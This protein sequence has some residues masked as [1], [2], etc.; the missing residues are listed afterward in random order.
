MVN[1][2]TI[3]LLILTGFQ[4]GQAQIAYYDALELRQKYI[5]ENSNGFVFKSD[6]T[7]LEEIAHIILKFRHNSEDPISIHDLIES[8]RNSHPDNEN[9]NPF[10]AQIGRA[11]V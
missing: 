8:I 2:L 11:H 9:Y 5:I 7:S 4:I 3:V 6:I 10:L 1:Q